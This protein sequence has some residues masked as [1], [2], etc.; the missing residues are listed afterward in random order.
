MAINDP[1]NPYQGLQPPQYQSSIG[2]P[3]YGMPL[4]SFKNNPINQMAVPTQTLD[5]LPRERSGI[6]QNHRVKFQIRLT[7]PIQLNS[8]RNDSNE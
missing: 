6:F 2:M 7:N 8:S 4:Q 3:Y 5:A 1:Y